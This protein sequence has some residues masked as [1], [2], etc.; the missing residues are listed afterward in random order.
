MSRGYA[1]GTTVS[2][3][4]SRHELEQLLIKRGATAFA[5]GWQDERVMIGFQHSG[6]HIRF[7][8]PMPSRTD[9]AVLYTPTRQRRA[10]SAIEKV[11]QQELRRRWRSLLLIVKAKMEA[12]ESGVTTFDDEFLPYIVLPNG[13]TIGEYMKPQ[14]ALAYEHNTMPSLLPGTR[15]E[16]SE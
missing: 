15:M 10:P 16:E 5:Y 13:Q 9:R 4:R 7:F 12:I 6:R 3:E 11:F 1:S 2:I 8:L 14:I